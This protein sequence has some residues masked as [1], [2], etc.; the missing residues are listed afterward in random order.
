ML[1]GVITFADN[2]S[3]AIQGKREFVYSVIVGESVGTGR[4]NGRHGTSWKVLDTVIIRKH[5]Q[6]PTEQR[7]K[8]IEIDNKL[9]ESQSTRERTDMVDF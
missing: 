4:A 1:P 7:T 8:T 5:H 2:G 9:K 6:G 3:T